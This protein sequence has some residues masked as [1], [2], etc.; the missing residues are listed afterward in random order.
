MSTCRTTAYAP[1]ASEENPGYRRVF[2]VGV[3]AHDDVADPPD[4][5]S[6]GVAD[7]AAKNLRERDH[8]VGNGPVLRAKCLCDTAHDRR[9]LPI[10]VRHVRPQLNPYRHDRS[11]VGLMPCNATC[12]T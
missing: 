10:C 1:R 11:V 2:A 9:L 12:A 6:R 4:S 5:R 7:R 8:P 3:P